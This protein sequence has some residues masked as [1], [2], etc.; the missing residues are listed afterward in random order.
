MS[1]SMDHRHNRNEVEA[2]LA[3]DDHEP[4]DI[5]RSALGKLTRPLYG[6]RMLLPDVPLLDAILARVESL[7]REEALQQAIGALAIRKGEP[8]R[9]QIIITHANL[10]ALKAISTAIGELPPV[11]A[12]EALIPTGATADIVQ[13]VQ[14]LKEKQSRQLTYIA[15]IARRVTATETGVKG[16]PLFRSSYVGNP[17]TDAITAL[18]DAFDAEGRVIFALEGSE[19]STRGLQY[20][21]RVGQTGLARIQLGAAQALNEAAI[22]KDP[23]GSYSTEVIGVMPR[24]N[25]LSSAPMFAPRSVSA[26]MPR[27]D[28]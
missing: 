16:V 18:R 14:L 5:Y 28:V 23:A 17:N 26:N 6:Y 21:E 20:V 4:E 2:F 19:Y 12:G 1:N 9:K 7:Y 15:L 22:A 25:D 24:T 27:V 13:L 8:R 3:S 10:D 11:P